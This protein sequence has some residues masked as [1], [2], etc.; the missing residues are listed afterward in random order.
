MAEVALARATFTYS[1]APAFASRPPIMASAVDSASSLIIRG[2]LAQCRDERASCA[3]ELAC[4]GGSTSSRIAFRNALRTA[5]DE[6]IDT[7]LLARELCAAVAGTQTADALFMA[8]IDCI[9]DGSRQL[10]TAAGEMAS[11]LA[12]GLTEY[13]LGAATRDTIKLLSSG[14]RHA[15]ESAGQALVALCR[16]HA[17]DVRELAELAYDTGTVEG[18]SA[19]RSALLLPPKVITVQAEQPTSRAAA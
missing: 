14:S 15:R 2:S 7:R 19:A 5:A 10:C 16:H 1:S 13:G 6:S 4:L 12:P 11:A 3:R 8:S 17:T 9:R 18:V